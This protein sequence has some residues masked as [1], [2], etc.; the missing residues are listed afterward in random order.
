[1]DFVRRSVM[2]SEPPVPIRTLF[3]STC[4]PSLSAVPFLFAGEPTS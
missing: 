4:R 1:M 2:V 3:K